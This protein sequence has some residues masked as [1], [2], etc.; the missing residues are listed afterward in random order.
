M[1]KSMMKYSVKYALLVA[2]LFVGAASAE[3]GVVISTQLA[4][5]TLG[6][7]QR[8][9]TRRGETM[10]YLVK[11]TSPMLSGN[12]VLQQSNDGQNWENTGVSTESTTSGIGFESSFTGTMITDEDTMYYRWRVVLASGAS[13]VLELR[14]NDD[15]VS[16]IKNNKRVDVLTINDES[17][18]FV[19]TNIPDKT[20]VGLSSAGL[21]VE[22]TSAT[23]FRTSPAT[24][25][26][27]R[28]TGTILQLEK[29]WTI[30][31]STGT[32]LTLSAR[33]TISTETATAGDEVTFICNTSS[34]T[35][36]DDKVTLQGTALLLG[37]AT[38]SC[39]V[40]DMISFV[41]LNGFWREK[42][43]SNVNQ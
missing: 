8:I 30:I 17:M 28:Y 29:G 26:S 31:G 39:G 23:Q 7:T 43:F 12:F 40:N 32:G 25:I 14:D 5:N 19:G 1:K 33:P 24:E 18:S 3:A 10:T 34:I 13:V 22:I 6:A 42:W 15:I 11:S 38:R 4:Q 35:F 9:L 37:A 21:N 20:R 16:V 2:M 41:Y 27:K 36:Q